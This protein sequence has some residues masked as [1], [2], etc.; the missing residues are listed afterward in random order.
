VR[1]AIDFPKLA[2]L[3]MN[4]RLELDALVTRRYPLD[5]VN[6]AFADLAAGQ[7]ARGILVF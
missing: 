2:D 1:P 4:G 6:E 7:L 3:A 5:Q